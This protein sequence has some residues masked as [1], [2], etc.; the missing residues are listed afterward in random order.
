MKIVVDGNDGTGKT[1]LVK[2]L[3]EIGYNVDDRGIPTEMTDDDDIK[4][5]AN[6]FY[7]ILDCDVE[8]SQARLKLA[9]KELS[10]KYHTKEDLRYYRQRFRE[11]A[12]K[13]VPNCV[14]VPADKS[15]EEVLDFVLYIL[16]NL[17]YKDWEWIN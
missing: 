13:L 11:V 15:P 5:D 16:D 14:V 17:N 3:R 2:S 4:G 8:I 10:E 12:S 6:H 9:G 1:T 7:I